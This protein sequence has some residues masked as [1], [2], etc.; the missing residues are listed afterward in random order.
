MTTKCL[1]DGVLVCREV[2]C[3]LS[4]CDAQGVAVTLGLGG[5]GLTQGLRVFG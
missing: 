1:D 2:G 3:L 5:S 4:K